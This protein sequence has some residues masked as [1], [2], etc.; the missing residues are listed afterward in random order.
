MRL[1]S[2]PASLLNRE[3]TAL[4]IIESLVAT[5]VTVWLAWQGRWVYL[6]GAALVTPLLMLRTPESTKRGVRWFQEGLRRWVN[7]IEGGDW[8]ILLWLS[9]PVF[10]VL[11]S[12]AVKFASTVTSLLTRLLDCL[13][14]V[15]GN[16]Y[17]Q[18]FCIDLFH[19]PELVPGIES[20]SH[21]EDKSLRFLNLIG[22]MRVEANS[23]WRGLFVALYVVLCSVPSFALAFL[24]R[25]SLKGTAI[26][27]APLLW[28][29]PKLA[30]K[31]SVLTRMKLLNQSSRGRVTAFVS[32]CTIVGF[33]AKILTYQGQFALSRLTPEGDLGRLAQDYVAP[34]IL[35]AWQIA[36]VINAVVALAMFLWAGD[37]I[38]RLQDPAYADRQSSGDGI[39][40]TT[41]IL[42]AVLSLY[43]S[44]CLVY[45]AIVRAQMFQLPPLGSKLFPWMD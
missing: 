18:T 7:R 36:S 44:S 10:V 29:V 32:V 37:Q 26:V 4:A 22:D 27:W 5:C 39:L 21:L 12:V 16:W 40:R 17:A 1:H 15:P 11:F 8:A 25:L 23:G 6:G 35:P 2:T 19:P 20:S 13:L 34:N 42:R 31:A 9:F 33:V 43:T 30:P 24:Y 14:A 41:S 38:I 45:L 3:V 28:I